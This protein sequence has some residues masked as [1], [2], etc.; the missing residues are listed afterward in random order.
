MDE[1]SII[2]IV[3][4]HF[5]DVEAIYLFG[6]II[7]KELHKESDVDIAL[8]LPEQTA[9]NVGSLFMNELRSELESFL[10]RDVDLVN[11][12]IVSTVLQKEIIAADKR[13]YCSNKYAADK[14]EMLTLSYYQKLNEERKEI[15]EEFF[16]SKRAYAV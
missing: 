7:N 15:L 12:R 1:K 14:F 9:E 10:K 4:K 13:I 5:V 6:S 2:D 8:L 3:L 11:L 16:K